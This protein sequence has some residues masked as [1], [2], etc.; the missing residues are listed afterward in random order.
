M[1][2]I[3]R[4][5][6]CPIYGSTDIRRFKRKGLAERFACRVTLVRP[7]RCESCDSRIY[8]FEANARKSA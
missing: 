2:Y 6:K 5:R 3:I 1:L 7:F 4:S 8:A